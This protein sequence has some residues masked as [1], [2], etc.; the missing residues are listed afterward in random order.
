MLNNESQDSKNGVE[1]GKW[2]ND[3]G[4]VDLG[5]FRVRVEKRKKAGEADYPQKK[6]GCYGFSCAPPQIHK[7]KRQIFSVTKLGGKTF[8]K[9]IK[10]K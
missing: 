5:R 1:R 2:L 10:V 3:V 7:L 9:V 4:W 6:V 8:K